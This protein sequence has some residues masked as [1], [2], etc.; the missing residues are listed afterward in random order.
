MRTAVST[1]FVVA[2]L[3]GCATQR[4]A[5]TTP[6][7]DYRGEVWTWDE[8]RGTVTLLQGSQVVRVRVTPDQM[9]GL[10]MHEIMTVHG[11]AEG[12]VAL[13]QVV[14]PGP[15][16]FVG[17]SPAQDIDVT[18]TVTAIDPRGVMTIDAGG[19][20]VPVWTA[21]PG[22]SEFK[23]GDRVHARISVQPGTVVPASGAVVSGMA[24]AASVRTE[25]GDYAVFVA[26]VTGADA[27][28]AITLDS[29]RGLIVLP[30]PS[31][32]PQGAGGFVEVRSEVHPA[33]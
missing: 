18:G 7:Q 12:P 20:S 6:G 11:V 26:P 23:V 5:Q 4:V 3:A 29:P 31:G 32:A 22:A 13:E 28:G 1:F 24:P 15:T 10:R 9:N 16:T 30:M 33:Q 27:G 8:Q 21:Q 2:L 25:P 17:R 19:R 14:I